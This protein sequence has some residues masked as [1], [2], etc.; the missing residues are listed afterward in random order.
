MFA[1]F[2]LVPLLARRTLVSWSTMLQFPGT[3]VGLAQGA[4]QRFDLPFVS[5]LL[6]LRQF[7]QL[8]NF[9]HLIDRALERLNDFHDF[10]N[11]LMDGGR[12]M[13]RLNSRDPFRQPLDAFDQRSL[14]PGR[15]GAARRNGIGINH[16]FL[17]RLNRFSSRR[18]KRFRQGRDILR[19]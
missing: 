17:G 15:R 14:F 9:L 13:F 19:S 1:L 12:A 3:F 5:K 7:D 16:R 11:G 8:Q 6:A 10:I 18:G 4:T 2:P